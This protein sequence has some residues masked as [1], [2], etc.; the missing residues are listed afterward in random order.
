MNYYKVLNKQ[1]FRKDEFSLVPI[2]FEDRLDIMKWRNEQIYHLRQV[3]PL[4]ETDQQY[5]FDNIVAKLF[6]QEEPKQ[7]LFSYLQDEICIG[8]GGLVHINWVD[9][10]AEIS[11]I[12]DT[13]LEQQFFEKHWRVYLDLIEKVAFDQLSLHKIY[14]YAFDLRPHLYSAIEKNGYMQDA[15]LKEHCMIQGEFRNVVIHSKIDSGLSFRKVNA[16]DKQRL[17]DWANDELTRANSFSTQPIT[18]A[19]H[20]EWFDK[21]IKSEDTSYYIGEVRSDAAGVV[22]FDKTATGEVVVGILIDKNYRG[23]N[24][25]V[26]F[27]KQACKI[28]LSESKAN[29]SAYIKIQNVASVKAFERAGFVLVEQLDIDGVPALKFKLQNHDQ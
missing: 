5:Y 26:A 14:T 13:R 27:L 9:R 28:Y 17:F 25:A 22:R 15:V 11:F 20:S 1:E 16:L 3:K 24:L 8:Y 23:R 12:M 6:E 10:N 7:L 2:R 18:F 19:E 4:T 21:K 29:I